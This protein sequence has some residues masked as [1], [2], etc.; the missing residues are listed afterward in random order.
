MV[1][2]GEKLKQRRLELGLTLEDIQEKTKITTAKLRAIEEGNLSYFSYELSYLKF[3]I[4]YY[5]QSIGVSYDELSDDFNEAIEQYSQTQLIK[6]QED[7]AVSNENIAKRIEKNSRNYSE[8][9]RLKKQK[10][11]R[12]DLTSVALFILSVVVVLSILWGLFQVIIPMLSANPQTPNVPN[13]PEVPQNSDGDNTNTNDTD[14]DDEEEPVEEPDVDPEPVAK[15]EVTMVNP[16]TYTIK[17]GEIK[18]AKLQIKFGSETWIQLYVNDIPSNNPTSKIYVAGETIE[19]MLTPESQQKITAHV[20]NVVG[21]TFLVNDELIQL[22]PS[23]IN[24]AG[25]MKIDF[26]LE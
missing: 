11:S 8:P 24:H 23:I 18:D 1:T 21:N 13:I 20:G 6:R 10:R 22:D 4:Q 15:I 2:I 7:K 12:F 5:A 3:Y 17:V 14:S 16:Q 9:A 19:V 26:I 25:G